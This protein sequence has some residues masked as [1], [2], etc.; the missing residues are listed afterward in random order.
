MKKQFILYFLLLLFINNCAVNNSKNRL[1]QSMY[2][3]G[4]I[5]QYFIKPLTFKNNKN[6][7]LLLDITIR[8]VKED[9]NK[10]IINFTLQGKENINQVDSAII[11]RGKEK[12]HLT[13]ILP[14]F[15]EKNKK[16]FKNR[17]TSNISAN[18]LITFF[19]GPIW[20]IHVSSRNKNYIYSTP[21]ITINKIEYIY[22]NVFD[23]Y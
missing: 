8:M 2:A 19:Q 17:Y 11:V 23:I 21:K 4:G 9:S 22:S 13:N 15:N 6:N 16:S 20:S 18:D 7:T 5:T 14:L 12:L 10:A 1:F 3:G